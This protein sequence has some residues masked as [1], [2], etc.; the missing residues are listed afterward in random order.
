MARPNKEIKQSEFE[1]LCAMQCT[2]EE[3]AAFFDCSVDTIERFCKREYKKSFADIFKEKRE[4]GKIS[5]RR[6]QWKLAENNPTLSIWLGKQYLGQH[7]QVKLDVN[8]KITN[9][10]IAEVDALIDDLK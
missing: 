6:S 7:D 10:A 1:K 9:E 2:Q 5:L 3:I 8:Q 4:I